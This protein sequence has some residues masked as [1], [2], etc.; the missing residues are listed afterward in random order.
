MRM[1]NARMLLV[2]LVMLLLPAVG[3]DRFD[4]RITDV[5]WPQKSEYCEYESVPV[6]VNFTNVG[7][8]AHSFW[9]AYFVQDAFGVVWDSQE[10]LYTARLT[11]CVRPGGSCSVAISWNAQEAAP[12]GLYAAIVVLC[13]NYKDGHILGELDRKRKDAAF[14]LN[15][16]VTLQ[17][18][19]EFEPYSYGP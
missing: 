10:A 13:R 2:A 16:S 9:V 1:F 7:S 5:V 12:P 6:W 19:F 3:T 8:E 18:Y 15:R 11:P 4:G 14:E 17:Q